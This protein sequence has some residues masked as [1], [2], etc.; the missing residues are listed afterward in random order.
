MSKE[1]NKK[2]TLKDFLA[3]KL[4][5]EQEANKT[6]DIYVT[7]M[8]RTLTV[9]KPKDSDIMDLIDDLGDNPKNSVASKEI[10]H[11]FYNYCPELQDVELH[12]ALEIK[13]PYDTIDVLFDYKDKN[14]IIKQFSEFIGTAKKIEEVNEEIK[15]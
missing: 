8:D 1:S 2:A 4:N 12:E 15:N 9:R 13:D 11:L 14:E 3:K 7:S 10:L 5:K 6:T